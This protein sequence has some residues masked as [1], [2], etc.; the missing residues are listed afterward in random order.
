M[1]ILMSA[2]QKQQEKHA[3]GE[4][5]VHQMDP[6]M[7]KDAQSFMLCCS[8]LCDRSWKIIWSPHLLICEAHSGVCPVPR[9]GR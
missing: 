9:Y 1:S 7:S 2:D 3:K 5:R 8:Q 4:L 6:L